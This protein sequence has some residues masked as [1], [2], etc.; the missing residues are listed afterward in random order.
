MT[1]FAE[2]LA[3]ARKAA[4]MTQEELAGA[5]HVTRTTISSWERGRTQPDV[6]SL[7][8]LSQVLHWDFIANVS[9]AQSHDAFPVP[10]ATEPGIPDEAPPAPVPRRK[11]LIPALCGAAAFLALA[12][13]FVLFVLPALQNRTAEKPSANLPPA[14]ALNLADL[15]PEEPEV[16][17]PDWFRDGNIRA[18]DEPWL[19]IR[20]QVMVNT[21]NQSEPFWRY[22]LTFDEV[23]GH[24]FRFDQL[25]WFCFWTPER[26]NHRS[27]SAASGAV[28]EDDDGDSW[29]FIGGDPVQEINGYGFII[30]GHDDAGNK[31][32][33]R[34]YIDM[35]QAPRE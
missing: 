5:V 32:S 1:P 13:C 25:D 6:E 24:P 20:T 16:F 10:E 17:T 9:T 14:A 23:A 19:D 28:W 34:T 30:Y 12:V 18:K 33:F 3:A 22:M 11:W 21:D 26:Y 15:L 31:M 35:T 27:F 8:L 7:R 4:G 2:Q 29:E